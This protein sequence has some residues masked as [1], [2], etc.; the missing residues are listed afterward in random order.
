[1]RKNR[2]VYSVI[3][4]LL[5]WI[6]IMYNSWQTELIF[7][8]GIVVPVVIGI[9]NFLMA[10]RL[11]VYFD[12][13]EEY[14][15]KDNGIRKYIMIDNDTIF[16]AARIELQVE[17]VD[18]FGHKEKRIIVV[19]AEP[20]TIRNFGMDMLFHHY[21][22]MTVRIKQ[23]RVYDF[24]F[25]S[26]Y[27]KKLN[28]ETLL[29]IFPDFANKMDFF[30]RNNR[31]G[32]DEDE[33]E[34]FSTGKR[35]EN[36]GEIIA[37]DEYHEGD[38]V[39]N[40]HWKLSSKSDELI[41]K[42]FGNTVDEKVHIHV[43]TFVDAKFRYESS[44]KL[45]GVV[46]SLISTCNSQ[47]IPFDLTGYGEKGACETEA[48]HLLRL[49]C[50]CNE[51]NSNFSDSLQRD[52]NTGTNIYITTEN[53]KKEQLPHNAI[54]INI[55][56]PE[57]TDKDNTED[58]KQYFLEN[59]TVLHLEVTEQQEHTDSFRPFLEPYNDKI[60]CHKKIKH[61][62]DNFKYMALQS[63]IALLAAGMAVFSIYD[64]IFFERD[65]ISV[66]FITVSFFILIHFILNVI[67][68]GM[69]E[70][71]IGRIRNIVIFGGYLL[72]LIFGGVFFV[73]DG[74]SNIIDAFGMDIIVSE[75]DYGFFEYSSPELDWLLILITYAVAD[76][77]YNFCME[78]VLLV[79][80]LI[81]VPLISIS[82]IVGYVPPSYVVLFGLIYFPAIF[83][84][85]SAIGF[86]K[87]KK[88][89]Y[90]SDDYPYTGN[91]AFF[92]G[93]MTMIVTMAAFCIV[94]FHI[95]WGGY[96]RPEW[97][98]ECKSVINSVL[99]EG[100]LKG[101]I[102]ILSDLFKKEPVLVS[103]KRGNL[104]D[105]V[106][107][108]Y[109]GE[110]VLTMNIYGGGTPIQRGIY[111]K[112]FAGT[113]YEGDVWK[114]RSN[115][116]I[117]KEEEY[118]K[119][120]FETLNYREQD[121]TYLN[122]YFTEA[123][124]FREKLA[125]YFAD[126]QSMGLYYVT[127]QQ[128]MDTS[129]DMQIQSHLEEDTNIYRPYF[130]KTGTEGTIGGDGYEY[131]SKEDIGKTVRFSGYML[132]NS[133]NINMVRD[134]FGDYP[135]IVVIPE[136]ESFGKEMKSM[137]ALEKLYAE[138]V[139]QNYTQVPE[140]LG[141][142]K[143]K[144]SAVSTIYQGKQIELAR[145]DYQYRTLGYEPYAQ[146]IRRYFSQNGFTYNINI[147]RKNENADFIN[148]FMA[149]KTGYCIHFASA[150]VM[151]FRSMGIPARYA[152]GYFAD[153]KCIVE[154]NG[155]TVKYNITDKS[156]HA[157][158]E[159]YQEGLGW[160]PVEVTP[161]TENFEVNH[162]TTAP[163]NPAQN[164][165]AA[166]NYQPTSTNSD[167]STMQNPQKA[168]TTAPKQEQKNGGTISKSLSPQAKVLIKG[169][170]FLLAV[171]AV[172]LFRYQIVSRR[173]LKKLETGSKSA[174]LGEMERQLKEIF[175]IFKINMEEAETNE[176]KAVLLNHSLPEL[177]TEEAW[178]V[179]KVLDK[180]RYG[181]K[182]SMEEEEVDKM[183]HF[184]QK[185]GQSMY[186]QGKIY[187]KFIYKYI[188]CLY[189]KNK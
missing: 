123:A 26:V 37:I 64:V 163:Q 47:N 156:A 142:L 164:T 113:D 114:E 10:R 149:R 100:N 90:L 144:F 162:E 115:S 9:V 73:F 107:V 22:I 65:F 161:G 44:D 116:E 81:V 145:G 98:T 101:G 57:G 134:K 1:M 167:E 179:L 56:E 59:N 170:L 19:N 35:G 108:S 154:R 112:S 79:H 12:E 86:G 78:F 105:T 6:M 84:I 2:I 93:C 184:V 77:I 132:E 63:F 173:T 61:T 16:P 74:V 171:I 14:C 168:T 68:E 92:S 89:K 125:Q 41:V 96:Q 146:Y 124:A 175:D 126:C 72:I 133:L 7:K 50:D 91:V 155:N 70:K 180:F 147:V 139:E 69:E 29:Y 151:M 121:N 136:D 38:D 17:I 157:W 110:L 109:T 118:L 187:E 128:D 127:A 176:D 183:Y 66:P 4:I 166:N 140:E 186:E 43:D 31:Y 178:Y 52:T 33:N 28:I 60:R 129:Y 188:K 97:M 20:R 25:L 15:Q 54:Y 53:I 111:L 177:S 160:V 3:F 153:N 95:F 27:K 131:F 119:K 62:G 55:Q 172:V 104:D 75:G 159:I 102:R 185:Y 58:K 32:V 11:K 48:N 85:H 87:K 141:E 5:F 106:P 174:R 13:Q 18:Y 46:Y 21:G 152:E 138:Y 71:R 30:I 165:T 80:L 51:E 94:L 39:R 182:G 45:L 103:G 122:I 24:F 36:R 99:E 158:V 88:R 143:E 130:S 83:A 40:I 120:A 42:H 169:I 76:V 135:H 117:K 49:I 8:V 34:E 137:I 23:I 82:M 148:D 189:L 181:P 67:G 150:A